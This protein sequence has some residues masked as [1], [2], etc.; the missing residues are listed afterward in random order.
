MNPFVKSNG[1]YHVTGD[2]TLDADISGC[3][4]LVGRDAAGT[5]LSTT[6][7]LTVTPGAVVTESA[8]GSPGDY[9]LNTVG[10]RLTSVIGLNT[11]GDH[12]TNIV[13]GRVDRVSGCDSSTT[14]IAGGSVAITAYSLHTDRKSVV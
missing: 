13:G 5:V 2:Y 1:A 7:T 6:V 11:F 4:I 14:T 9:G 8:L 12:H 3:D 10:G